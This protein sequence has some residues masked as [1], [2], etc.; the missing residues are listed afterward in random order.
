MAESEVANGNAST[1]EIDVS[2][3]VRDDSEK[4]TIEMVA[5]KGAEIE[6]EENK[7]AEIEDEEN[8]GAEIEDE[9]NEGAEIEAEKD[10]NDE[11]IVEVE[12][13]VEL[14][15]LET[16]SKIGKEIEKPRCLME[17]DMEE[18]ANPSFVL[19][20]VMGEI[21]AKSP[22]SCFGRDF[23]PGVTRSTSATGIGRWSE[24]PLRRC[25][26]DG[27]E[28]AENGEKMEGNKIVKAT[29]EV[30]NETEKN[31]G[32]EKLAAI[33]QVGIRAWAMEEKN[34]MEVPLFHGDKDEA[35]DWLLCLKEHFRK[36][37]NLDGGQMA[38][39][40]EKTQRKRNQ[41]VP[42]IEL[43]RL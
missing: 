30:A 6:E 8:K 26:E 24:M 42:Y 12:D 13:F 36:E 39:G 35:L 37:K 23:D 31:L 19:I 5:D 21:P 38:C 17:T 4:K 1:E 25:E 29:D 34:E 41:M 7:G 2:E 33:L 9:E 14:E 27:N 11:S 3:R 22:S 10:E 18:T 43:P 40:H 16:E 15:C 20:T 28:G 32:D